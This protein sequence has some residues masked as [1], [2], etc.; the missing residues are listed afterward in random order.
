MPKFSLKSIPQWVWIPACVYLAAR[1]LTLIV[2]GIIDAGVGASLHAQLMRWD[3]KWYLAAAVHGWPRHLIYVHGHVKSSTLAFF[4]TLP[5]AMRWSAALTGLSALQTGLIVSFLTGLTATLAIALLVREFSNDHE[6]TK[7]AVV[8]A[9]F[10]AAYIFNLVYAEG[11][12][13][14]AVA[15]GL[16]CLLK[17]RWL[18][19]GLFG[20]LAAFT[21]PIALAFL[22]P[23]LYAAVREIHLERRWKALLAPLLAPLGFLG[24]IVWSWRHTGVMNAWR[25]TER[26][27]WKGYPS[28][29]YTPHL[30]LEFI[31]DPIAQVI[32]TWIVVG[33]TVFA[34]L[35]LWLGWRR[36]QPLA[37]WLYGA[38]STFLA[39]ISAPVG[40]R[41]RFILIA[42]PILIAYSTTLRGRR[43][44]IFIVLSVVALGLTTYLELF[45]WAVFP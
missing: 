15:L 26:G 22:V 19:A 30:F 4:P 14:T 6:A 16:Y 13:L 38:A 40:L 17:Q 10:P 37:V 29:V 20:A 7:A 43:W 21:A 44:W 3:T 45:T 36:R 25:L 33:F 24:F 35:G 41:P 27:G 34:F 2:L 11:I 5:L 23:A 12:V 31:R 18:F 8:F 9:L 1:L 32:T 39:F 42:F 28:P